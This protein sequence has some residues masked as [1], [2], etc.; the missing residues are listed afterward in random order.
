MPLSLR[1]PSGN[2][3]PDEAGSDR[4]VDDPSDTSHAFNSPLSRFNCLATVLE[5]RMGSAALY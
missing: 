3:C 2:S 1:A 4:N 5:V